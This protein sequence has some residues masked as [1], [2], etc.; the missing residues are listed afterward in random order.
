MPKVFETAHRT[1]ILRSRSCIRSDGRMLSRL[2]R[3]GGATREDGDELSAAG[4]GLR[5]SL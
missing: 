5:S 4:N 3:D 1:R 2:R